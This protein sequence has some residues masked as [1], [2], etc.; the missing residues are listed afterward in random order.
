MSQAQDSL[1]DNTS[2]SSLSL[3]SFALDAASPIFFHQ[4]KQE[5]RKV[6]DPPQGS[7]TEQA[8]HPDPSCIHEEIRR[9][10]RDGLVLTKEDAKNLCESYCRI[11]MITNDGYNP[12][13]V[14]VAMKTHIQDTHNFYLAAKRVMIAAEAIGIQLSPEQFNDLDGDADQEDIAWREDLVEAR[15]VLA[16]KDLSSRLSLNVNED[17]KPRS[18]IIRS[19]VFQFNHKSVVGCS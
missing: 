7:K 2:N 16:A 10:N 9:V 14:E 1:L 18:A 19:Q 13:E 12:D 6:P 15:L 4:T 3:T 17:R 5:T 11:S 8:Q